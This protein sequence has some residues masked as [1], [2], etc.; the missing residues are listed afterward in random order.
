MTRPFV[1]R[2]SSTSLRN[3]KKLLKNVEQTQNKSNSRYCLWPKRS[4]TIYLFWFT[5]YYCCVHFLRS[6]FCGNYFFGTNT[7]Q[8]KFDNI[9]IWFIYFC[10]L[11]L[12]IFSKKDG[13]FMNVKNAM[14]VQNGYF[15]YRFCWCNPNRN[16][17]FKKIN[18]I[19]RKNR[20]C[21]SFTTKHPTE[22]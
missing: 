14:T 8:Y 5:I 18:K 2:H 19:S 11:Y 4:I 6:L 3:K 16:S 22:L 17:T 20:N 9:S 1:E 15:S 10:L 7:W 12:K 21:K 13:T